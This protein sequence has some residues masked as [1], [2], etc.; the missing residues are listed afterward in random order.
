ML[1]I[2]AIVCTHGL[3][4]T[5]LSTFVCIVYLTKCG[6]RRRI[7]F[8]SAQQA[9]VGINIIYPDDYGVHFY[10]HTLFATDDLIAQ[11]PDLVLRFLRA[12]LN[13]WNYIIQN[14]TEDGKLVAV[15]N[16][17][18]DVALENM[19][20]N[21]MLPLVNTGEDYIGWMKP[22]I[23][24]GMEKTLREQSVLAKP[25]DVTEVYTLQFLQQIY[26]GK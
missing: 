1:A 13:G 10:G 24:S 16:P 12:T 20:M 25:L 2:F 4:T 14:P 6:V 19:R 9:G 26:K 11:N 3:L 5:P 18:A 21:V 17:K 15:Y 8:V 23:W 22:E 7:P